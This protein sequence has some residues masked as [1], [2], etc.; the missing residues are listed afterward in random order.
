MA[1]KKSAPKQESEVTITGSLGSG[2]K[3]TPMSDL[4][5]EYI[6]FNQKDEISLR[7]FVEGGQVV[8]GGVG[9][10]KTRA[11]RKRT[12]SIRTKK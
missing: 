5:P 6:K 9:A 3:S 8:F 11:P 7:D 10:G 2:K 12:K 1:K 4:F